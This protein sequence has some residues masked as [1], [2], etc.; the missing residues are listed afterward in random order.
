MKH[1]IIATVALWAIFH[2][3]EMLWS[4]KTRGPDGALATFVEAPRHSIDNPY[5][6][7]YFYLFGLTAAPALDPGKAGYELWVEQSEGSRRAGLDG[8]RTSQSD[9]PSIVSLES[10]GTGWEAN[11]PLNEFQ[12]KNTPL[13][14]AA[15]THQ[16]VLARYDRWLGMPFEDRGFGYRVSPHYQ[17]IMAAHRLYVAEGFSHSPAEGLERLHKELQFWRM[18]LREAKTI[19]TKVAAQVL[20]NDDLQ[21]LSRILVI[22]TL[23][24]DLLTRSL[25]LTTPL[26]EAEYSLRWP[27]RNEVALAFS[28][29][30]AGDVREAGA[31]QP[32][33]PEEAWLLSAANLPLHGFRGIE[34]PPARSMSGFS[35]Q[36][37]EMWAAYYEAVITAS[38]SRK[39]NLPRLREVMGTVQR[40]FAESLL[41]P[42]PAEPDW[43]IFY[44]QLME[45]DTRLRLASLQIQLR[46]PSAQTAVPTR[47]A[48]VGSQFFDPFTGLPMLWSPTQQ[49]IYSVGKDRL[50]DGG[51]PTF[52]ISVPAIVA[53]TQA[54][55]KTPV[56]SPRSSSKVRR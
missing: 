40:G 43:G 55:A 1:L 44:R 12:K 6:N 4:S 9:L 29:H 31:N 35:F 14:T 28:E 23:D 24:K 51:D 54:P 11:E 26:S 5:R 21:L 2:L 3:G 32:Q 37:G 27:V 22:P 7:G 19:G 50:D 38:E 34:H 15:G 17:D 39:K 13:Q 8:D 49:K 45:T 20:M 47:L 25:Q 53:S 18:V 56:S 42:Q 30:R 41:N 52:D 48:E 46:R 36:S 33:S 16:V 10:I